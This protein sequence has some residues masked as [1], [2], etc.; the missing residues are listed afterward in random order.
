MWVATIVEME[1]CDTDNGEAPQFAIRR[2]LFVRLVSVLGF[3]LVFL[4]TG[5]IDQYRAYVFV[6]WLALMRKPSKFPEIC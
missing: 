1:D 5:W 4:L 3:S 2:Y 6:S